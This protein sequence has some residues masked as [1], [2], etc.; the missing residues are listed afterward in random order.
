[1]FPF[2]ISGSCAAGTFPSAPS[3][4]TPSATPFCAV[5][6][7][8]MSEGFA[9]FRARSSTYALVAIVGGVVVV[10]TVAGGVVGSSANAAVIGAT[11]DTASAAK[12]PNVMI[13]R[14]IVMIECFIVRI[15][16]F[17]HQPVNLNDGL[18]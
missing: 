7:A 12:S 16:L 11:V 10:G 4:A 17:L 6:A 5:I 1:L 13:G 14:F 18:N 2:G 15:L 3:V 8:V 9:R